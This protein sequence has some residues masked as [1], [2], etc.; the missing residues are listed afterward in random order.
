MAT[1]EILAAEIHAGIVL[2]GHCQDLSGMVL[3]QDRL[4][5]GGSRNLPMTTWKDA[6]SHRRRGYAG[7]AWWWTRAPFQ[8]KTFNRLITRLPLVRSR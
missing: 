6:N 1:S 3:G 8:A 5:T 7:I 2:D 4:F